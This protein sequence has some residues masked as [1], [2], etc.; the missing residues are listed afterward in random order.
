MA[1]VFSHICELSSSVVSVAPDQ[2]TAKMTYTVGPV[3]IITVYI[4]VIEA[5]HL[6]LQE[7]ETSSLLV[8][9]AVL[10]VTL[11]FTDAEL[12]GICFLASQEFFGRG[13]VSLSPLHPIQDSPAMQGWLVTLLHWLVG[14]RHGS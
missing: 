12:T 4:N 9:W 10:L 2:M 14:G 11:P 7:T 8:L 1:P 3:T 5:S 13:K 6:Y